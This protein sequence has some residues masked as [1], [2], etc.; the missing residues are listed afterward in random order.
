MH[1][2][3][4]LIYVQDFFEENYKHDSKTLKKSKINGY[5]YIYFL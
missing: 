3:I 4:N 5:I 2:G 1:L